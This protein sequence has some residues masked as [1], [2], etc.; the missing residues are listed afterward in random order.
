MDVQNKS[1]RA[2]FGASKITKIT[3]R[4]TPAPGGASLLIVYLLA[5][6]LSG[7]CLHAQYNSGVDGTVK[8]ASGA[9]V[10]NAA[11]TLT[12]ENTGV[13]GET[14]SNEGGHF[15]LASMAPGTYRIQ[16][17]S[18]G[19]NTW[20]QTEVVVEADQVRTILPV[21]EVGSVETIVEVTATLGTV[22]TAESNTARSLEETLVQEAPVM[23]RVVYNLA[24]LAPGVTGFTSE[25]INNYDYNGETG[26][27]INSS[28]QRQE[29]NGFFLDGSDMTNN[30]RGGIGN[31]SLNPDLVQE[32]RVA[33]N[34]F[35][36]ET[37]RY[38]GAT[39]SLVSK[40]G[41]N[42][43][44]GTLSEFHTNNKLSSRTVFEKSVPVSR[45][46][47][48]GGT[49]GGPILKNRTF[50]F[51][52]L[53]LLRSSVG[54]T[55]LSTVETPQFRDYVTQNFP[56]GVAA[57][58]YRVAAPV[59]E[60]TADIVNVA[61]LRQRNPGNFPDSFP[62]D[63]PAVGTL[64]LSG[65]DARNGEQWSIRGDHNFNNYKDRVYVNYID[66]GSANVLFQPRP[67]FT[68]TRPLTST[69]A[70]VSWSHTFSPS[71]VNEASY[72]QSETT[73]AANPWDATFVPSLSVTGVSGFTPWGP[74]HWAHRVW[75]WNDVLLVNQGS[76]QLRFGANFN[77]R[78][79]PQEFTQPW[80]RPSF[81]FGNLIDFAQDLVQSQSGP[82]VD[83]TTGAAF[84]IDVNSSAPVPDGAFDHE[85]DSSYF[86]LFVQ[87]NWKVSSNLTV[88]L[89][90]RFDDYG[91][92]GGQRMKTGAAIPFFRL[93][94]GSSEQEQIANGFMD[95]SDGLVSADRVWNFG[96]RFGLG[97]DIFGDGTT[98]L[99]GGY[100]LYYN[101]LPQ[102]SFRGSTRSNP[103]LLGRPAFSI[104]DA[105]RP[106]F[107]Y[108]LESGGVFPVPDVSFEVLPNGAI[109]GSRSNAAGN[110]SDFDPARAH[111][112][113]VALQR[114]LLSGDVVFEANYSGSAGRKLWV[115]TDVNRFAGDLLDGTLDRLH[116]N[117]ASAPFGRALAR[118]NGH[119]VSVSLS[120]R[121]SGG[122]STR[123]MYTYGRARDNSSHEQTLTGGGARGNNTDVFDAF[124]LDAQYGRADFD[125]RKRLT[126]DAVWDIPTPWKTGWQR[127]A[128]GG[129]RLAT[130]T[131]LQSGRPF[132]VFTSAS[133]P[134]GDYNADGLRFDVP[135]TPSFGNE[136][137]GVDSSDFLRGVFSAGDFPRPAPGQGGDL[138]RN[139]YEGP[140]LANVDL[141][142]IKHFS[143][144]WFTGE[145]A[146]LQF[147]VEVFNLFNRVN[148][149][150]V[151]SNL[152]SGTFGR[153]VG[154]FLP[155]IFQFG[156]RISF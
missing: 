38:S 81:G 115:I 92:V 34:D 65:A 44:H 2:S 104:F 52:S 72:T 119:V 140:G 45:S 89:G 144:P 90:I 82:G 111:V 32:F 4:L 24:S 28:G 137:S 48:F 57:E 11:V 22:E 36:A 76:H 151:N 80:T 77:R 19:F 130:I 10:P 133:L 40:S 70:K 26:L 148:L 69:F 66:V 23:G 143:M 116:P 84:P 147:R 53:H 7:P 156:M 105:E 97:W 85:F 94:P 102:L 98:A 60:A 141:N 30:A 122:W 136:L 138:G 14:N 5:L 29:S 55:S 152:S 51:G 117:F 15:R 3:K 154:S 42:T 131:A 150:G 106:E 64:T 17:Q 114:T 12:N 46:N 139:P 95:S 39:F 109:A 20:T 35:S 18:P 96:P 107:T 62:D 93:G 120:K 127:N 16:V 58:I 79:S 68:P 146:E 50:I 21:L 31:I 108:G 1:R 126:F 123:A 128:L 99:R 145:P 74:G 124:N 27:D 132:T 125:I 100:G 112:W 78:Y 8:D 54:R 59:S 155:R 87:D 9:V 88:N 153:S 71:V 49:L 43:W 134:G 41:T 47:E 149:N 91:R 33:A 13:Q 83:P 86:S 121:F 110:A 67:A 142:L 101:T 6:V 56:N 75:E 103:P 135:N 73:G 113:M 61:Q 63:L 37:G 129:W 118:S 25:R